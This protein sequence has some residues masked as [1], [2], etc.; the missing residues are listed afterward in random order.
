MTTEGEAGTPGPLLG[1]GRTADVYALD[2]GWVLRRDR[3][4]YGDAAAEGAV[5]AHL[6]RYGY[7]VP[8]VRPSASRTDLVME[9]LDGPT[10]LH[11]CAA[12]T[13]GP[14]E[15]GHTLAGLLR[16]LHAVPGREDPG[17]RVLHLDLHP[18]NVVL[19]ADG[20]RVID[21][22]NAEEG[23]PALDWSTSA[24]ILAQ[25]AVSA[26][27]LA[28]PA[29]PMLDALLADP[30]PLTETALAQAL[31]RRAADPTMSAEEVELLG[32][33]EELVLGYLPPGRP[34]GGA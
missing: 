9:R 27:P 7:P 30:S 29:R 18:D 33:A 4:G 25:V 26:H 5:M 17:T 11:A 24:V 16:A 32:A 12:G 23:D 21:W 1:S 20:P 13:L 8:A 34:R 15:A 2:D 22:T 31:R 14:E 28:A 19:T 3:R 6:R 10:M